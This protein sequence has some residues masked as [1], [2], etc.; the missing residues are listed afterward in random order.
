MPQASATAR[1]SLEP[2][3]PPTPPS[4]PG[5]MT[6]RFWGARGGLP[7]PGDRY[8]RYG[9]NTSCVEVRCG[10]HCVILDAGSGLRELGAA[11]DIV[12]DA[13]ILLSHTHFDHICGLPFFRPI[14]D[15]AARLRIWAG[16][17]PPGRIESALL[18]SWQAPLM[19]DL[20]PAFRARLDFH[21]F[22]PPAAWPLRPGLE[23]AT[24]PLRHPGGSTGYRLA[25]EGAVLCYLTDT[26]HPPD[27]LDP[28][29]RDFVAGADVLIYDA[30]YTDAEYASHVGWG[31]STW[32]AAIRLADAA[33]VARLVLFH[34]D[35]DHDDAAMDAILAAAAERRPGTIAAR[36]GQSMT[37]AGRPPFSPRAAGAPHTP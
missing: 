2:L 27:G 37:I 13:D 29:L 7:T 25:W 18:L 4:P 22:A 35:P 33:S 5:G 11:P 12:D 6:V 15:P 17:L 31:H 8:A 30:S 10:P 24:A 28:R 23:V 19:P 32:R 34:H 9:G 26:E 3:G 16:H 14:Y 20:L 36:E 1:T 21:D